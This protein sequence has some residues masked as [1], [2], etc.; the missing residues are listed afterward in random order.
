VYAHTMVAGGMP[1]VVKALLVI[2]AI[3]VLATL[4]RRDGRAG[5]EADAE[6]LALL[7]DVAATLARQ[8]ERIGNL[9]ALLPGYDNKDGKP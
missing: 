6:G 5:Q 8:E 9:E 1:F 7:K 3:A 2:G 4:R